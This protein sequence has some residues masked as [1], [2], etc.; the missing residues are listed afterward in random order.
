MNLTAQNVSVANHTY[1]HVDHEGLY[2]FY[3]GMIK[4]SSNMMEGDWTVKRD[5]V[6][7]NDSALG[8]LFDWSPD[9]GQSH[10]SGFGEAPELEVSG[11]CRVFLGLSD[12]RDK[13][14]MLNP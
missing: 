9:M 5:E 3:K 2:H 1:H 10:Y 13:T 11:R 7:G 4:Q 6:V 12:L 8:Y 14:R